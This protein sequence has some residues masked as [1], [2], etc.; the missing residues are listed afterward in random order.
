MNTPRDSLLP[1]RDFLK[2]LAA[3]SAVL[4]APRWAAAAAGPGWT[5]GT[6]NRP[7]VKWSC[8]DMLGGAKAA[9]YGVLGLQTTTSADPWVASDSRDYLTALK[10]KLAASGLKVIQ[11]RLRTKEDGAFDAACADIRRQ[12]DRARELGLGTLI[13]TGTGK[14]A[15]YEAW[16]RCMAYAAQY[17]ADQGVKI[18]TKP[19]GAVTAT[20]ADLLRCLE[21]VNHPNFGVWYD[22]GNI[23]Y[24]TGRDPLAEMEPLLKHITAFTAKDCAGANQEVMIQLGQGKVDFPALFRRLKQAGFRGP[25]MVE[26]GAVGATAA[27]TTA[28]ARANREFLEGVLARV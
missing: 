5:I 2:T 12:V 15:L 7:W 28:N 24:Y 1:R 26:G 14:P 27:A 20:A 13:N 8:D 19:H 4:A 9:G 25:I 18:V 21:K 17:G 6:L 10:A 23:V 16:Y 22:P 11:G 3:G